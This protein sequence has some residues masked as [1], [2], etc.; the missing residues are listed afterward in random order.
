MKRIPGKWGNFDE[1]NDAM[2]KIFDH[3]PKNEFIKE[4]TARFDTDEEC[5]II[6]VFPHFE[7]SQMEIEGFKKIDGHCNTCF[8]YLGAHTHDFVRGNVGHCTFDNF[9]YS[10]WHECENYRNKKEVYDQIR[11]DMQ[12]EEA[13]RARKLESNKKELVKD[14][15][16]I[17]DSINAIDVKK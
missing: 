2:K 15:K 16:D 6:S 7:D 5:F 10:P 11:K 17:K 9:E 12:D 4:I 8:Y 14:L 3:V 13:E 1:V